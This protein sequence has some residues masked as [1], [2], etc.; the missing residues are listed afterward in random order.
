MLTHAQNGLAS[1][2]QNEEHREAFEASQRAAQRMRRLIESLLELAR[3]EAGQASLNHTPLNLA[4]TVADC[5]QLVRPLSA[6]RG[7]TIQ[8]DLTPGNCRG[9]SDRLALVV[10]NLLTNAIHHNRDGGEVAIGTRNENGAAILTVSDNGPGIS[11]EHLPR[12]FDRFYR[13]DAARPT[14][15]GRSG[16]GLAIAKAIVEA[17]GGTIEV[18]SEFGEGATFTVRLPA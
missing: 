2:C 4:E 16:L 3:L 9:D 11:A 1:E 7:I 12:I 14:A 15:Q 18:A 5:L 8:S 17:H 10:T 13:A 6:A